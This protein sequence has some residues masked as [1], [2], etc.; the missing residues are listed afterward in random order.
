MA[1]LYLA[2]KKPEKALET[3]KSVRDWHLGDSEVSLY[4]GLAFAFQK[5]IELALKEL[6]NAIKLDPNFDLPYYYIGLQYLN[7]RPDLSKKHLNKF[8]A[9][10]EKK[11]E[12][13]KL[14][15]KAQQ[16]L[17]KL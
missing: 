17:G 3:L 9:L 11:L 7:S 1:Q 6:Q 8:L 5:N 12:N 14:I 4:M 2:T 16:L 13:Q 10:S 15:T